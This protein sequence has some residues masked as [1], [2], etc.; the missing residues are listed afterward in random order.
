MAT[1]KQRI[2]KRARQVEK[3][4]PRLL[5]QVVLAMDRRLVLETPVDTGQARSNWLPSINAP[6]F[7]TGPVLSPAGA[8]AQVRGALTGL[9]SGDTVYLSNSL[10]YI[11]ALNRGK[12]IQ[13]PPQYINQ[14]VRD[15]KNTL[16]TQRFSF[17][18]GRGV[19][20]RVL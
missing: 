4:G 3:A 2:E 11:T 7:D 17:F 20:V 5:R 18:S 13:A 19:F 16:Q 10:P 8:Q 9:K 12:S 15:T 6:R 14:I 1:F